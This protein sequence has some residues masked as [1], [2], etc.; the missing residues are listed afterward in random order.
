MNFKVFVS[1]STHDITQ[2]TQLQ[3]QLIGTSIEVF[4]AEHSVAPSQ[5]LALAITTAIE[6]CDLFVLLWS[7]NAQTSA[8]VPQEIGKATALKKKILP[9]VLDDGINLPGFIQ[10]LKYLPVHQNPTVALV[11]ARQIIVGA[12]EQKNNQIAAAAQAEKEKLA[13]M[14]IGA[15]LLWAFSK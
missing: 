5:D 6:Q 3:Q 7:K 14:G 10:N 13:L 8:W 12:Y 2:V 11:Q 15:F 4:V 1:Y 9:L